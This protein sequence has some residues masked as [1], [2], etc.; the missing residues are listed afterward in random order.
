MAL[1]LPSLGDRAREVRERLCGHLLVSIQNPGIVQLCE[2][3][4]DIAEHAGGRRGV[5]L[6][7]TLPAYATTFIG[8]WQLHVQP[9]ANV[10]SR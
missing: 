6:E 1:Y 5:W 10:L 9:S 8:G 4:C 7:R 3:L 2:T